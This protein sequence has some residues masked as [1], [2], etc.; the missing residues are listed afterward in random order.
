MKIWLNL[1]KL[2]KE[3]VEA[4]YNATRGDN[5]GSIVVVKSRPTSKEGDPQVLSGKKLKQQKKISK[6]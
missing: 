4:T 1:L 5:T 6:L 2:R 3:L